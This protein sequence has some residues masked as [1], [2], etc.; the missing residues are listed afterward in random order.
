MEEG[1]IT[2]AL[3]KDYKEVAIDSVE[4]EDEKGEGEYRPY[5]KRESG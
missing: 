4:G 3:E 2:E 5:V 1:E